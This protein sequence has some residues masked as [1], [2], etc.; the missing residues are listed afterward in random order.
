M[1]RTDDTPD[2]VFS[3]TIE[4]DL[5]TVVP[6]L[7]GPRRPQDR[8]E[9]KDMKEAWNETL[10][11]PIDQGGFGLSDEEAAKSVSVQREDGTSYELKNGSVVI[12]A[13]TSCTNTS[14]PSVMLGAG[15]VAKKAVEKGLSVPAY[16]KTSLTPGSKVVTEYLET[17][18]LTEP[19]G[20]LGFTV[21]GY[22]CATC[23]GNS[24]PLPEDVA[25]AI[26]EN[27][28]TVASVLSG[29]RNFEGRIHPLVKANYLASPPLV[30]VY[31]LAGTV[32][33]DLEKDPIG[34]GSDGQPVYLKDIW[35]SAEEIIQVM[36]EAMNPDQF[37]R[38]YARVFDANE[39]WNN[40]PTPKGDLYDWDEKSTY[41]QE[42][43][44]FV[45]LSA[46]VDPIEE[47]HGARA[48]ALLGDSVTTDHISPAGSIAPDSPAGKYLQ[49]NGVKPKDFNSYGSR[50]GNDRVMTRGTFANIR[51]RNAMVPGVEGGYTKYVPT[52]ETMAI[53]D[54]AMKYHG[55]TRPSSSSPARSTEPEAPATGRPKGPT[56]SAS[57]RSSPR[58]SSGSTVATWWEWAS[59]PCSSRTAKAGN[60]S[61]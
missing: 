5:S 26:E 48:L 17:A 57:R 30:I 13:I 12:A 7:A 29:N 58:A 39:R 47:I 43:P 3:D 15:L 49:E 8:I 25:K 24:G 14:N 42:P 50:R 41:I 18:G 34:T 16:V 40:M 9:L 28:L 32:D 38:Q 20:K 23:I 31:A 33:I 56:S 19:L 27:D 53:Y 46:E 22:G 60:P 2:P 52:G 11:K 44:F 37:R 36:K 54:A 6:S 4:L 21:A 55:R 10:K 51:I 45:N 59:C 1:F 61:A 35:P